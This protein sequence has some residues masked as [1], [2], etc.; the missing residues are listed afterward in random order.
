MSRVRSHRDVAGK[1]TR[2]GVGAGERRRPTHGR[3]G[4]RPALGA[5]HVV[6]KIEEFTTTTNTGCWRFL[7]IVQAFQSF[8]RRRPEL[9][10]AAAS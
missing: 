7:R 5:A 4:K 6:G 9:L 1:R 8:D 3:Q 2:L 10:M